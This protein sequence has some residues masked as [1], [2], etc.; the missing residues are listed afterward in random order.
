MSCLRRHALGQASRITSGIQRIGVLWPPKPRTVN[1][2]LQ[3]GV[4][5][6]LSLSGLPRMP[7]AKKEEPPQNDKKKTKKTKKKQKKTGF[8]KRTSRE[9]VPGRTHVTSSWHTR[10]P[11]SP[12][13]EALPGLSHDCR[14]QLWKVFKRSEGD[15]VRCVLRLCPGGQG[16]EC[17][18]TGCHGDGHSPLPHPLAWGL[19][20]AGLRPCQWVWE[21]E[22][23]GQ[24]WRL[25]TAPWLYPWPPPQCQRSQVVGTT[26]RG[27]QGP[28]AGGA[29]G[30]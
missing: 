9:R 28:R 27:L 29:G 20:P 2:A 19:E 7:A 10:V 30:G 5:P 13:G 25:D 17:S 8:P 11:G 18:A 22:G 6:R 24:A 16:L 15:V 3:R 14:G 12:V 23:S 21:A 1:T 4:S 26:R